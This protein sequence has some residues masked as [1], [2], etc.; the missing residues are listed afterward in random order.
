[1]I[2]DAI[3]KA[4]LD[5]Q[6][7]SDATDQLNVVLKEAEGAIRALKLGV[8]A[9]V[10]YPDGEAWLKFTRYGQEW[11]LLVIDEEEGD[12]ENGS[13]LVLNATRQRRIQTV[14]LLQPLVVALCAA[15]QK[16][17][18]RVEA[19]SKA[20]EAFVAGLSGQAK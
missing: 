1:M 18:D 11:R 4:K 7:L 5:Q 17:I 15:L 13:V 9:Q 10:C 12:T 3:M 2:L 8:T 6:R 19:S 20:A 14:P 16:E